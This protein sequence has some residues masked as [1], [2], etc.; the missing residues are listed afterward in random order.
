MRKYAR[1][2]RRRGFILEWRKSH[3]GIISVTITN[4]IGADST[5][6]AV[7]EDVLLMGK[8]VMV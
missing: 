1:K 7:S 3:P 5:L 6:L 4:T 2:L 8:G